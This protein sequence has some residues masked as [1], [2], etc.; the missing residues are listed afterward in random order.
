MWTTLF[1]CRYS[2]LQGRVPFAD[3]LCIGCIVMTVM[4]RVDD[5]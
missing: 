1:C 4:D 2:I 5:G 3:N